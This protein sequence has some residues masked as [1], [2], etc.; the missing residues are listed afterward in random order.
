MKSGFSEINRQIFYGKVWPRIKDKVDAMVSNLAD[1]K[2]GK[3]DMLMVEWGY[4]DK[5]TGD[6]IIVAVTHS[7]K[8]EFERHW[9]NPALLV[10]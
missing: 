9:V 7:K 4:K 8:A 6:L 3:A 2:A 5:E 10:E 1:C